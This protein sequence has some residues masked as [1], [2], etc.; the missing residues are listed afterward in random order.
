MPFFMYYELPG[1]NAAWQSAV[2]LKGQWWMLR[3][4]FL[5]GF[6]FYA[7][8]EV[9]TAPDRAVSSTARA[10]GAACARASG[11]HGAT[12]AGVCVGVGVC[13]C[14]PRVL[15]RHTSERRGV[16]TDAAAP[17]PARPCSRARPR[18]DPLPRR[19]R[20]GGLLHALPGQPD[21]ARDRC[22]HPRLAT[23]ACPAACA[24]SA[25]LVAHTRAH[26]RTPAGNT[27][28][29]VAI[30]GVTVLVFRNPVSKQSLV[31]SVIAILGAMLYSI[32]KAK[33]AKAK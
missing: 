19:L 18:P 25:A 30:I 12:S 4:L 11:V 1:F 2:A 26:A 20:A 24:L 23:D 28:K 16:R 5:D 29:R 13:V 7:Y 17:R 27:I 21:H 15:R 6:Y 22:A 14:V 31:G 33:T 32:V 9:R 10:S 8:N 3:Q